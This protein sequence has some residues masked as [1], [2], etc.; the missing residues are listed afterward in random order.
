MSPNCPS[1]FGWT[2]LVRAN[3]GVRRRYAEQWAIT[4]TYPPTLFSKQWIGR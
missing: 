3:G 4:M 2:C 1:Q